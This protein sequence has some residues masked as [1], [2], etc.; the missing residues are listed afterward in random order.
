MRWESAQPILDAQKAPLP[1][2]FANHYVISVS[3]IPLRD[4]RRDSQT[5]DDDNRKSPDDSLDNLK[6]LTSLEAK[7]KDLVLAGVVERGT[8]AYSTFL[9][10]FS[11]ELLQLGKHDNEVAFSTQLG[12]LLVKTKFYL[13]W[14]VYHK[15]LAI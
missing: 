2:A 4:R 8:G 15:Q 13:K 1:E 12:P 3:G 14:M 7:G 6:Q 9:F 10:G 5:D 11:K